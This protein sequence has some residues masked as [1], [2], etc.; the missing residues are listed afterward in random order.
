MRGMFLL[1]TALGGAV[2]MLCACSSIGG[3]VGKVGGR[4]DARRDLRAGKL[5]LEVMGLPTPWDN[6]YSRLL[7]ERYGIMQRGVGGCMVG[8]RVASH[9]QYYN[10]IMEA[11]IT[12]RFGKNVF[13][14]T[15]HEAVK[16]TPRRRP[17]P[18]L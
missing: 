6:T 2:M 1:K 3:W 12:R 8:S 9:A 11:E 14:R 10:E 17:N 13:E 7:K 16:M 18:P 15:L 5:V 4:A